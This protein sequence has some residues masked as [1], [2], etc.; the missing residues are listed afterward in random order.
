[1]PSGPAPGDAAHSPQLPQVSPYRIFSC[2]VAR[3]VFTC[4]GNR[5]IIIPARVWS[6]FSQQGR[7]RSLFRDQ[8]RCRAFHYHSRIA[9]EMTPPFP[10]KGST[11]APRPT[12]RSTGWFSPRPNLRPSNYSQP[13]LHFPMRCLQGFPDVPRPH[14]KYSPAQNKIRQNTA[15]QRAFP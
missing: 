4:P 2:A 8:E 6:D 14:G 10:T 15:A 3:H 12:A 7:P 13:R 1:M 5:S 9:R 11:G